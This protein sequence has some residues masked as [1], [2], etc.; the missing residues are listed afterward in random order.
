MRRVDSLEKTL[1]L[2]GIGGQRWKG[3]QRIR[4]LD[5]ITDSMD[6]SLSELR[7]W[8]WTRR[9]GVLRFMGSQ[10]VGHDW[11]TELNWILFYEQKSS[12]NIIIYSLNA[13]WVKNPPAMRDTQETQVWS[14]GGEDPL[15]EGMVTH[16]SILAWRILWTEEPGWLQS[17][18]SRSCTWPSD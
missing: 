3:R 11:A 15:E 5:G 12:C 8:W 14:L 17:N 1:I 10:R 2:G 6:V 4:C 13:Q 9:P 18:G 7:E 16:S